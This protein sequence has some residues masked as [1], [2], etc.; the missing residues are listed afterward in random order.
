M[1]KLVDI[2]PLE[3]RTKRYSLSVIVKKLLSEYRTVETAYL[4]I[5]LDMFLYLNEPL[6]S[7]SDM[8]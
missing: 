2:G 3:C 6:Q 8:S 7:L 1:S 4:V 5:V